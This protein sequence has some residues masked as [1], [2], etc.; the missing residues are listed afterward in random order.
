MP[1][2]KKLTK[3]RIALIINNKPLN[4]AWQVFQDYTLRAIMVNKTVRDIQK[5]VFS[6]H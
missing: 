5:E 4:T 6:S 2:Q 3:K 1:K